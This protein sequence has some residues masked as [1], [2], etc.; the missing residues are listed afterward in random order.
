MPL[1]KIFRRCLISRY[2][3]KVD[4]RVKNCYCQKKTKNQFLFAIFIPTRYLSHETFWKPV[5]QF[6]IPIPQRNMVRTALSISRHT[7]PEPRRA[8]LGAG[9]SD[10]FIGCRGGIGAIQ[11]HYIFIP[12][13]FIVTNSGGTDAGTRTAAWNICF[14]FFTSQPQSIVYGHLRCITTCHFI[15]PAP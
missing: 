13:N 5:V 3:K 15:V 4:S 6:D 14:D 1:Y 9:A 2:I 12:I 10:R 11:F 7:G 8:T